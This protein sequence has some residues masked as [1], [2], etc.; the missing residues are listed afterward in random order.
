M[1]SV[2]MNIYTLPNFSAKNS[3]NIYKY[4]YIYIYSIYMCVCVYERERARVCVCMCVEKASEL[5]L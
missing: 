1:N 3:S 2:Q 4:I 5:A